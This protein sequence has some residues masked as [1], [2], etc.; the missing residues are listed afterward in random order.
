MLH[1]LWHL[2]DDDDMLLLWMTDGE[3]EIEMSAV[4]KNFTL[5]WHE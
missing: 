5:M 4:M 2:H 3:V 1:S